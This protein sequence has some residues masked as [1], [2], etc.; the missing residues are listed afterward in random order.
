MQFG[1]VEITPILDGYFRLDGGGMFGIVPRVLWEKK[2]PP[3]ERH[4]IRMAV[5]CLLVR[6]GKHIV[7]IDSGQGNKQS[8]AFRER[9]SIEQPFTLLDELRKHGVQPD[10]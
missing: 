8:E 7:L 1:D 3:D 10:D 4:R 5:R 2:I 9:Y 6:D